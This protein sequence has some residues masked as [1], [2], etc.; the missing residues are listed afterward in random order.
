[1]VTWCLMFFKL[2]NRAD[3]VNICK[4]L[5]GKRVFIP[6]EEFPEDSNAPTDFLDTSSARY[7]FPEDEFDIYLKNLPE[8]QVRPLWFGPRSFVLTFVNLV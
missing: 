6:F 8:E 5:M 1:M 4:S 7:R 2:A 3:A